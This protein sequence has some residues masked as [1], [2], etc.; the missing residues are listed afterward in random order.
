MLAHGDVAG[1]FTMNP[2]IVL[3]I[4]GAIV[5]LIHDAAFLPTESRLTLT[6]SHRETRWFRF[7][8]ISVLLANW[9]YLIASH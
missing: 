8:A 2:A 7:G 3:G 5:L 4:T 1:A 9:F 6:I